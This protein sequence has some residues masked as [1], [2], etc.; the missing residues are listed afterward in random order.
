M[1]E[2][3]WPSFTYSKSVQSF[4]GIVDCYLRLWFFVVRGVVKIRPYI[5]RDSQAL[6]TAEGRV[7][8]C[9]FHLV[10]II[11]LLIYYPAVKAAAVGFSRYIHIPSPTAAGDVPSLWDSLISFSSKR[12][13]VWCFLP[14]YPATYIGAV[15]L[16]IF[17][18]IPVPDRRSSAPTRGTLSP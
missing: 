15:S 10:F 2:H 6:T 11:P 1:A 17:F 8:V 3:D 5:P 4:D 9:V 16:H 12:T 14:D 13:R 7:C 18:P